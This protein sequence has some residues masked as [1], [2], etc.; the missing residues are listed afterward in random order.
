M[1]K[2]RFV[3][4]GLQRPRPCSGSLGPGL[5]RY[6]FCEHA[7]L[8]RNVSVISANESVSLMTLKNRVEPRQ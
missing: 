2:T 8:S 6:H 1:Q 7:Q 5:R 4:H 3:Y